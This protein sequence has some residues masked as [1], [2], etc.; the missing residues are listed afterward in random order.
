MK[1]T[2]E[3]DYHAYLLRLWRVRENE[4]SHWR[5]SL[6]NVQTGELHG[7]EEIVGLQDYLDEI[8]GTRGNKGETR[9][10]LSS[11]A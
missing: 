5:A 6:E 11:T 4:G 10:D 3:S 1:P 7:F 2:P 9:R 8:A